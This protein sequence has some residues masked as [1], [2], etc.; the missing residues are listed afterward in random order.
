MLRIDDI[1][2]ANGE[3]WPILLLPLLLIPI[4]AAHELFRA[5]VARS[6]PGRRLLP[7]MLSGMSP[8]RRIAAATCVLIATELLCV[9][10]LR[11]RAGLKEVS[12]R[13]VGV[14]IAVVL[15]ASRSMKASDVVPDRLTASTIEI[16]RLLKASR[17]NRWALVPFAGVA[18]IQSPLTVDTGV[19]D[20]YL[21]ELRV[22]DL[23]VP[24]TAIGRALAVAGSALG[25]DHEPGTGGSLSKAIVLFTDGENFEGDPEKAAAA[26]AERG[27]R[28][29]TVGV[30]TPAGQPIPVL[31]D[32]GN[33]TGTARDSDGVA[34][35][36]SKLNETLLKN[37]SNR[38]GGKY[39]AL[40]PGADV[41]SALAAE[42]DSLQKNEYQA[43]VDRLLEDRFQWPL[44]AALAFMIVPFLLA[45][46]AWRWPGRNGRAAAMVLVAVLAASAPATTLAQGWKRLIERDHPGVSDALALLAKGQYGDAAKAL[47]DL[48]QELP[49]RPDLLYDL[50]LA[51]EKAGDLDGAVEAS[52]QALAART[53][54]K[55]VRPDW[56]TEARLYHAKGTL[57]ARKAM[58][59]GDEKKPARDVR[60]TWR[61]AVDAL[62]SAVI[63]DPA[64]EDTRRNLELAA[65]AAYPPCSKLDDKFEPNNTAA[66]AQFLALNPNSLEAK[67]DLLLCPG[68]EDWFRVPLRDGETL[69]ASV[70]EPVEPDAAAGKAPAAGPGGGPE[71][72][73]EPKRTP[74]KV[75][76]T[77]TDADGRV[78]ADK[79]KDARLKATTAT[80]ALLTITGPKEEDGIPYTLEARVIPPCPQGDDGME[81]NDSKAAAKP[82]DDGDHGLRICPNND[83]WFTYTEKQGS[84]KEVA[85][86]VLDGE[87]PLG[88]EVL[89]ADGTPLDVK[90]QA[91]QGGETI[92]A[93]LPKAEQDAPFAIRVSGGGREGFYQLSVRDPKGG[94]NDQQQQQQQKQDQPQAGS[95]TLRELLD[96]IDR[97][98]E[99][100]EA[101]D[102]AKKS[103]WRDRVPDKDW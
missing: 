86:S 99:N 98:D 41:A 25:V 83:D 100:L 8:S 91:G 58:R 15:D 12:V 79:K 40:A 2:W 87:G 89:S 19:L 33:V 63:Q 54:A 78:R 36:L 96:A 32:N 44:G 88:L 42:I 39:F 69:F 52:N 66:Q 17:G 56:P 46:A 34:P 72:G 77:L 81:P 10:A 92:T 43:Q 24:G 28:I 16:T 35:L 64:A 20:E 1:R 31:D 103:P 97:N 55:A 47:G 4:Y 21:K 62:T 73:G 70:L 101:R 26:L 5:R 68:D 11:P 95:R 37:L 53:Q 94:N 22:T 18:F 38:T 9:A 49:G 57:L 30:G 45:G 50:A 14:D 65:A 74:A 84:R 13:G 76:L 102:A 80:S 71:A 27:V 59:E 51:R 60:T 6:F 23:P 67:E 82:V 75:D 48:V 90:R 85:V 3:W 7:R 61:Q 29:Y 93:L